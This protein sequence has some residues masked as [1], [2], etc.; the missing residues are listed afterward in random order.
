MSR[1]FTPFEATQTLPLVKRIVQDILTRGRQL[2]ELQGREF[3]TAE[4]RDQAWVRAQELRDLFEEL[5]GIG[6]SF[7]CPNFEFG[8]VDF[9]GI[10]DG[11]PVH[12]CWR[13]DESELRYYHG[14][15]A[16]FG[17]RKLIPDQLLSN[18]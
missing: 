6:C 17:G 2:R 11:E 10:I 15:F 9:P 16:G 5:E 3:P 4:D 12:L 7:R 1:I 13:D 14:V 18:P 8:L